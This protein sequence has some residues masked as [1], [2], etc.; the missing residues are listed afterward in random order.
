MHELNNE[1]GNRKKEAWVKVS[2]EFKPKA[3]VKHNQSIA[4][5]TLRAGRIEDATL[6]GR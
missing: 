2:R 4:I 3:A 5:R 1:G 6:D